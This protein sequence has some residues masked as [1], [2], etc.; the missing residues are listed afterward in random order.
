MLPPLL[1]NLEPSGGSQD[2]ALSGIASGEAFGTLLIGVTIDAEATVVADS[3]LVAVGVREHLVDGSVL[4]D[5]D[6][7]LVAVGAV[8]KLPDLF[9][10]ENLADL[11]I[12]FAPIV[13]QV[14]GAHYDPQDLTFVYDR[15]GKKIVVPC[16]PNPVRKHPC[17]PTKRMSDAQRKYEERAK[18]SDRLREFA[19]KNKI[20]YF[21]DRCWRE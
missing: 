12:F 9:K 21:K 19:R 8:V 2:I 5:C 10:P 20:T 1:L 18:Q 7:E 13:S 6:S 16:P 11:Y 17:D 4:F 3:E 14:E 15:N